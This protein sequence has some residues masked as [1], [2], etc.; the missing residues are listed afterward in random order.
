MSIRSDIADAMRDLLPPEFKALPYVKALD[1]ISTPVVMVHR[2]KITR[3]ETSSY[4]DH[5]VTVHV[6]VPETLGEAAEDKADAAVEAALGVLDLLPNLD[7]AEATRAPYANFTGY[8]ITLT[9][10]LKHTI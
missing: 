7:W 8:E 10:T 5:A 9:A 2:S 4:F 1:N 6:L 3:H